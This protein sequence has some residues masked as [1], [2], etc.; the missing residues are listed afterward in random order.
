MKD[1][2]WVIFKRH[3]K[4]II[5][6][7]L[8]I[9]KNIE[10]EYDVPRDYHRVTYRIEFSTMRLASKGFDLLLRFLT[11]KISRAAKEKE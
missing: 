6:D 8:R 1:R 10:Y 2:L 9:S 3:V 11:V 4:T 5:A 7:S